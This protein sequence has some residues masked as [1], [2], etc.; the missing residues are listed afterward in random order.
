MT[1]GMK[2]DT[3]TTLGRIVESSPK[4]TR[5]EAGALERCARL[6]VRQLA[7]TSVAGA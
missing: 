4:S 7:T 2:L 3:R 5:R 1:A 6:F